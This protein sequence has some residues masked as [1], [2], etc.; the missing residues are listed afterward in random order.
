[1]VALSAKRREEF[2]AEL[3]EVGISTYLEKPIDPFAVVKEVLRQLDGTASRGSHP[4]G[5]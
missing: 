4:H 5:T 2:G 1:M 3:N